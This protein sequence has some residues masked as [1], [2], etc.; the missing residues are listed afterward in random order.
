M[1]KNE[2]RISFFGWLAAWKT[3]LLNPLSR[4]GAKTQ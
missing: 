2:L 3:R 1:Q 4:S